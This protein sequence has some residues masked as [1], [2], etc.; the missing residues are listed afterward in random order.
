MS[1]TQ[2]FQDSIS[3]L[4]QILSGEME[5]RKKEEELESLKKKAVK[6]QKE[7]RKKKIVEGELELVKEDVTQKK[8][9][10]NITLYKWSA[11]VRFKIPFDARTYY[12]ALALSLVFIVYLA[13]LGNYGLMAALVALLF[14]IYIVGTVPPFNVDHKITSRGI[15]SLDKLY[16]WYML[17]NFWFTKKDNEY[18]M[19]VESKLRLPSR[20]LLLL[21][22]EELKVIFVLLQDKLLYKDIR[23]QGWIEKKTYGEYIR[24]EDI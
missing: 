15:E 10:Q 7:L 12:I 16:E 5:L 3:S 2:K 24:L 13:I 22:K 14:F 19:V 11:P 18:L 20:I 21:T 9:V 17:D 8:V 4:A 6:M 23:S 1:K